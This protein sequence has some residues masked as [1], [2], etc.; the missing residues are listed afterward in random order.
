MLKELDSLDPLATELARRARAAGVQSF[1]R[2]QVHSARRIVVQSGK[3][4][5]T[6]VS[7]A[8]GHGLQLVTADGRTALA[9]RDDFKPEPA[10]E[11]FDRVL[12]V[13]RRAD[14]LNLTPGHLPDL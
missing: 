13:T 6:S 2:A 3:P 11:L 1:W 12:E 5:A 9:S 10:L 8:S 14:A 4:E 7:S